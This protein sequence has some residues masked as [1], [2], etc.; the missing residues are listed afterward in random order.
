MKGLTTSILLISFF[1]PCFL[2]YGQTSEGT[3]VLDTVAILSMYQEWSAA[4]A[5]R[6]PEG[7]VAYFAEGA[8]LLPP[9]EPPAV[10]KEAIR[11]WI[12]RQ[13]ATYTI[14]P[15]RFGKRT[16]S[17]S[18]HWVFARFEIAGELLP[19]QGGEPVPFDNKY[20]DVLQRQTDGSWRF[21]YR[22]WNSNEP[23]RTFKR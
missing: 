22:I 23:P 21:Y 8:A 11:Q 16:F 12:E 2:C 15:Q 6:G 1:L 14:R 7:Y 9:N 20:L 17:G 4:L 13:L 10:G 3:G 18:G 5:S 19:K